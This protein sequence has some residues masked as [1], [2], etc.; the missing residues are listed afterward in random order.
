MR[1]IDSSS[2][3]DEVI[4]TGLIKS[5]ERK[6]HTRMTEA[7]ERT[8]TRCNEITDAY[9]KHT[10]QLRENCEKEGYTE[11]FQLF[12]SQLISMLDEYQKLQDER[13]EIFQENFN[14]SLKESFYDPVIVD[15]IIH[16]LQEKIG[17]QRNL[18]IIIPRRV[19][20]PEGAE[21]SNYRFT[22]DDNITVQNDS[23][24]IRFPSEYLCTQWVNESML[25]LKIINK[26]IHSLI[27]DT[28]EVIGQHLIA[29]AQ[30]EQLTSSY[31]SSLYEEEEEEENDKDNK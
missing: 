3:P 14:T 24:A 19:P 8:L 10:V 26:K 13:F 4:A 22:D 12:F 23:L 30:A 11:G 29:I 25:N 1:V 28:L 20:I 9:Q 16:H 31:E 18:K 17:H 5:K 2:L 21:I 7:L 6:Q 27:P 15:R